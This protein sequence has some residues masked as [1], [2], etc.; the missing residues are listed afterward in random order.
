MSSLGIRNMNGRGSFWAAFTN[1]QRE[2]HAGNTNAQVGQ[3]QVC[4]PRVTFGWGKH[5]SKSTV[6]NVA[7]SVFSS[8]ILKSARVV[9]RHPGWRKEALRI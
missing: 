6:L 4:V 8:N 5:L 7:V 3:D 9:V 1:S 2:T